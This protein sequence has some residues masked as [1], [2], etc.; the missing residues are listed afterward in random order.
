VPIA[1]SG[2][3]AAPSRWSCSAARAPRWRSRWRAT[4]ETFA[5]APLVAAGAGALLWTM[6]ATD[7]T[8]RRRRLVGLAA[9]LALVAAT[10]TR[11]TDV[12]ALGVAIL[13]VIVLARPV[14]ISWRT[15]QVWAIGLVLSGA[16]IL[17]FNQYAYG[18][19]DKTGCAAGEITFSL[20][21]LSPNLQ[22]MP[23]HPVR[24]I[25]M[26]LFGLVAVGWIA[27]RAIT[28]RRSADPAAR[29]ARRRDA[30]IAVGAVRAT[31]G[32]G[33]FGP[34]HAKDRQQPT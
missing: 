12:V 13:A 20:S 33:T 24:A 32:S 26:L 14:G 22:H 18:A 10:F 15:L 5:D 30:V 6:L 27:V 3:G 29:A 4:L 1:G 16:G 17:A 19:W 11:Y 8:Q 2:A 34:P 7:A 25:P 31:T 28:A 9:I 23:S 21:A